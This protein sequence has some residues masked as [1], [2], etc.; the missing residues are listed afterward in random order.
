[1]AGRFYWAFAADARSPYRGALRLGAAF[2][3]ASWCAPAGVG[4]AA[5]PSSCGRGI[6]L[7]H[8]LAALL[9]AALTAL[10]ARGARVAGLVTPLLGYDARGL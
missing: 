4:V 10:L 3:R 8:G 2:V 1:M 5:A 6:C 7:L 9:P